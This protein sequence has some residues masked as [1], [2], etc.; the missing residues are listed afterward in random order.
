M[1]IYTYAF[2]YIHIC[3]HKHMYIHIYIHTYIHTYK[4]L[5]IHIYTHIRILAYNAHITH[6]LAMHI[7]IQG[8]SREVSAPDRVDV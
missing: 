3:T 4:H 1:Y 8:E 7:Y 2:I 5:Y 6:S